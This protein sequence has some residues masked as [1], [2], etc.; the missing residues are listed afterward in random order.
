MPTTFTF[1][2]SAQTYRADIPDEFGDFME[3]TAAVSINGSRRSIVFTRGRSPGEVTQ[4]TEVEQ[5]KDSRG[6][7]VRIFKNGNAPTRF[8]CWSV[9]GGLLWTHAEVDTDGA[10][11]LTALVSHLTVG[12]AGQ[13]PQLSLGGLPGGDPSRPEER[14]RVVMYSASSSEELGAASAWSLTFENAGGFARDEEIRDT[15]VA[16]V[17][18]ATP[19]GVTV[20]CDGPAKLLAALRT[21]ADAVAA[22]V[23]PA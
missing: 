12:T 15:D 11:A 13:A 3:M 19:Y 20:A 2:T 23:T 5:L 21:N 1:L 22:S 16:R 10:A 7:V 14:D 17:T 18:R 6:Q 4:G 9:A 8:A